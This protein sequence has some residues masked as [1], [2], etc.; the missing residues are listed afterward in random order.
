LDPM[1]K[2]NVHWPAMDQSELYASTE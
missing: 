1:D 2:W